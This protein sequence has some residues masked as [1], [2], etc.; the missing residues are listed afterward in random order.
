MPDAAVVHYHL[1]MSYA[2]AGQNEKAAEAFKTAL[3]KAQSGALADTI[4][5]E[6][7]KTTSQ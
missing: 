4:R 2:A 5:A 6:L 1:G 3:L 7:Q